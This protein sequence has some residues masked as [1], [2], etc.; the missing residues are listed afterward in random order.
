[1]LKFTRR[2]EYGLMALAYL[3]SR[4]EGLRSVREIVASLG[5]PQRLMAEV[6]KTLARAEV[7]VATRGPT[8]GYRLRQPPSEV[9]LAA[10][11]AVLE[12]PLQVTDCL[13]G[14]ACDLETS[15]IIRRGLGEVAHRIE[16][17][18][19]EFTLGDLLR[20]QR[21]AAPEG[22]RTRGKPA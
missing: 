12:G 10:V 5:V 20:N 16:G 18:L 6:L 19:E 11:V 21:T 8:G 9:S 2:T 4:P 1:M 15:C 3:G 7:V 13:N 17:L 22:R 14:G